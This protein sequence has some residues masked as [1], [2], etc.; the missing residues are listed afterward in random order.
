MKFLLGLSLSFF[1]ALVAPAVA[2]IEQITVG[3][4]GMT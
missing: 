1:L 4:N 3:V 2:Q